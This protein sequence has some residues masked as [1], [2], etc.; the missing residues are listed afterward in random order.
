M[1]NLSWILLIFAFHKYSVCDPMQVTASVNGPHKPQ[2]AEDVEQ[3]QVCN[4]KVRNS[5]DKITGSWGRDI[6]EIK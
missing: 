6:D 5:P 4:T 1:K 2:D 3:F